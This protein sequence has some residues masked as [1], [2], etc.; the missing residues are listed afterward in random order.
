[1]RGRPAD[2]TPV[3]DV[4]RSLLTGRRRRPAPTA[5]AAGRRAPA[6]VLVE[7][8]THYTVRAGQ[9]YRDAIYRHPDGSF[10][11]HLITEEAAA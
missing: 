3:T 4:V 7:L 1:M 2:E 8:T 10:W 5:R 11:V 6:P 9:V